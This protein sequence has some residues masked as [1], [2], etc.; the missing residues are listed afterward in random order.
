MPALNAG[1]GTGAN[2]GKP[3]LGRVAPGSNKPGKLALLRRKR[4]MQAHFFSANGRFIPAL[5]FAPSGL[6]GAWVEPDNL[7]QSH[8]HNPNKEEIPVASLQDSASAQAQIQPQTSPARRWLALD[9]L[10]GLSVLGML[11]VV[12]PGDW[13]ARYS[14]LDHAAWAGISPADW[15]FPSFLFCVGLALPI[16]LQRRLG[17]GTPKRLLLRQIFLR[18]CLLI[19]L[20][21]L[22]NA[23]PAFDWPH[24]R[25]PGVLQRIGLCYGLSA[26]LL[27]LCLSVDGRGK[28][29]FD[30]FWIGACAMVIALGYW[31]LLSFVPPPGNSAPAYD[32]L[33]SWPAYLDRELFSV[34]HLWP[35]GLTDGQVTY[36]PEGLVSTLPACINLLLGVLVGESYLRGPSLTRQGRWLLA[37]LLLIIAGAVWGT[38]FP[39]IK[40][41]WTS[42]FALFSGGIALVL[43]VLFERLAA[44][45]PANGFGRL[46]SAFGANALLAFVLAGLI[47]P[48]LDMP[49]LPQGDN[50][51]HWGQT[52][53]LQWIGN[54]Q[55]ASLVFSLLVV[56]ALF[57]LLH[58]LNQRQLWLRL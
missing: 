38:S 52:H 3:T 42:S 18:T 16:S 12:M 22:L 48:L 21:I 5:S 47:G 10:R 26:S 7:S 35:W 2:F 53:L 30:G 11:L 54:V 56:A 4:C 8:F 43:L 40:K 45:A 50:L 32:S 41:I 13:S 51:R 15:I 17:E 46:L 49:W 37:G 36:D 20:G 9:W 1:A 33:G 27:L 44:L 57:G 29:M 58:W 34:A 28:L 14:W 19:A 55:I 25:L 31:L 23:F 39:L 6:S 24:V